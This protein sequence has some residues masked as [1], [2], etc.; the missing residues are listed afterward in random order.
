MARRLVVFGIV[1]SCCMHLSADYISDRE[2]AIK[3]VEAGKYEEALAAFVRM[4]EGDVTDFQKSDALEQAALCANRLERYD[5]AMKLAQSIP[6][7]PV[8]KTV[9]MRLMADNRK[10]NELID[11]FKDEDIDNWPESVAGEAFYLRGRTYYFLKNGAA[12][13]ADLEKAVEYLMEDNIKGLALNTLGDTYQHLLKDDDRAI[14]TYR[15]VYDTRNICKHCH[16]AMGIANVL[17]RQEKYDEALQ[18]LARIDMAKVNHAYWNGAML[19]AFGNVL[20]KQ[21]KKAEAVAKYKEALR[22]EGV[23]SWQKE[24]WM[25]ALKNLQSGAD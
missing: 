21:G 14:E 20:A 6:L 24:A 8:S 5:Q 4:A 18:E 1:I 13:A 9:Q 23:S 15:R 7:Q 10:W 2:A 12:A 22:L 3:M 25:K 16:A 17:A 19:A 11:K